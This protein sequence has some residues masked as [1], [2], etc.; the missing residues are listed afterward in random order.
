MKMPLVFFM[1][2]LTGLFSSSPLWAAANIDHLFSLSLEELLAIKVTGSTLT[3]KELKT[4]PAAVTVFTHKQIMNLGLDS[5]DEL[6]NLVP[7]FQ[8]YRTSVSV[9]SYPFSARGRRIGNTGSEILILVDGLRLAE[10]RTSGSAIVSP[11]FSLMQVERVEFIRGPGSA[12]Y[13][14]NAMMGVINIITRSHVDEASI[15]VGSFNRRQGHLL[16]TVQ[17]GKVTMDLFAALE[18]D[19]GDEYE[20]ADTFSSGQLHTRDPRELA[21]LNLKFKWQDTRLNL[22]HNQ[23]IGQD[24]YEQGGLSNGFNQREGGLTAVSLQQAFQWQGIASNILLGYTRAGYTTSLQSTAPGALAAVSDPSSNDALFGRVN[25]KGSTETRVLWHND[26]AINLTGSLQFGFEVRQVYVPEVIAENNFDVKDLVTGQPVIRYY[27]TLKATTPV[28]EQSNRDIVGV[29]AQYQLRL[30]DSSHLTLGL[31]HDD[32]SAIGGQ[33]SPRLAWVQEINDNHSI[34]FLYGEAFRAPAE[35]ELNLLNNPVVL[36]NPDLAPETVQ[37]SELI[38]LGQWFDTG[39]SVGYFES[40]Y[41]DAIVQTSVSGGLRQFENVDQNPS[42]GIELELSHQWNDRWL[43]RG[44]YTRILET[45][46]LSFRESDTLVSF[47]ANFQ[48]A[49]WNANLV[50]SYQDSKDL[51]ALDEQGERISLESYWV[52]M[53]K[54]QYYL[55]PS[56]QLFMQV[57]NLPDK[58]YLNP[59]ASA[60]LTTGIPNR[61]REI[62]TGVSFEF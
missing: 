4:V 41:K 14:S 18:K 17:I 55:A 54:G 59:A 33:L 6:M 34:K 21:Q 37:S 30:F 22:H 49:N 42:K 15:S 40:H 57:K 11:K 47:M 48:Q 35:G 19:D 46:D 16:T 36:G 61:G 52:L 29:Y 23:F 9:L 50:A 26:W 2:L 7:G 58:G 3:P 38:W 39:M 51:P 62:L 1:L 20:L 60:R 5:L 8:S 32:F 31:R 12:V 53:A 24:F 10:P 43:L 13:G 56:L 25:F 28:Q 44:T 45:P 27:G